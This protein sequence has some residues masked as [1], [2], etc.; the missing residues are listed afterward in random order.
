MLGA[1]HHVDCRTALASCG[2]AHQIQAGDADLPLSSLHSP[3]YLSAQLT[4]VAD[5]PYSRR[6]RSSATNA[7][8]VRPTRLVTVGDWAFPV[9]AAKLWNEFPGDVAASQSLTAFRRH[10]KTSFVSCIIFGFIICTIAVFYVNINITEFSIG[11]ME[12][13]C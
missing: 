10:I 7:L 5:I 3:R 2:R 6:L 11:V 12:S 8:L 1:H 9:A 4:L 13:T